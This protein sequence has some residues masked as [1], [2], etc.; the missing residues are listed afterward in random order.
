MYPANVPTAV[1]DRLYETAE[2]LAR[3]WS[4]VELQDDFGMRMILAALRCLQKKGAPLEPDVSTRTLRWIW[5]RNATRD[6]WR[7]VNAENEGRRV[8]MIFLDSLSVEALIEASVELYDSVSEDLWAGRKGREVAEFLQIRGYSRAC[9]WAF[10]WGHIDCDWP[11]IV[12]L[13]QK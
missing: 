13:L 3:A 2:R 7:R 12:A 5:K 6:H 9:A 4:N 1:V 8:P 11:N 10:V